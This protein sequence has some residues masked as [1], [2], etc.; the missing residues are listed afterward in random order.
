M[1]DVQRGAGEYLIRF[2]TLEIVV[3]GTKHR[4]GELPI[5]QRPSGGNLGFPSGHSAA[6]SFGASAL[7]PECIPKS[8]I[9]KA[10]VVIAT[11][12]ITATRI[13]AEKP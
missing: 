11:D 7:V 9:L 1:F 3:H 13:E 8:P 10:V 2:V 4:L 5:N 6:A 12:F